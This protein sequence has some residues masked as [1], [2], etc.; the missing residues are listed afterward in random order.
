MIYSEN[1]GLTK[2]YG[3]VEYARNEEATQAKKMMATKLVGQRNL[4]VDFVD[5]SMIS[6]SDLQSRTLFVDCLP[7]G[8]CDDNLLRS[9][10][11]EFGLV[12]FCQVHNLASACNNN[13]K[14]FMYIKYV[15]L[16]K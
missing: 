13:N 9:S 5:H 7:R 11:A 3:F 16:K 1:T 10:F 6:L 4:R 14:Y 15:L 2:G 12:N 8:F